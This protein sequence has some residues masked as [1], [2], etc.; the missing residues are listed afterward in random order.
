MHDRNRLGPRLIP[1]V[2]KLVPFAL[3]V[4]ESQARAGASAATALI[5]GAYS[6]LEGL[7]SSVPTFIG[8]Q[9]DKVF[10]AALSPELMSLSHVKGA[11]AAKARA[12]LLSAAA[13]KLPAKTLYPAIIRLHASLDGKQREPLLGLLDLL[14]RALRYGKTGDV[15]ANYRAIFKLFLTVFDLRRVHATE[16]DDEDVVV[17]E[18]NALGAFVQFI[19]K[20]NEHM[21]RPLFLR[22][23]DWA[24]IDLAE[25]GDA[26]SAGVADEGL[27]ARRTVLYK[28]VDRLLGQLR[29]IFVPYFSFMLDQTVELLDAA[30]KGDLRDSD[31]WQAVAGALAKAFEYD[32]SGAS[33]FFLSPCALSRASRIEADDVIAAAQVSGR[34]RAWPSS[35][36]P[37][38]TSS[39]PPRPSSPSRPSIRS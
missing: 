10:S 17:I 36:R 30:A 8:G 34:A 39:R 29:S 38:R 16:L 18:D 4:L 13:K 3:D 20:L 25:A 15:G 21:F 7:F 2:A 37:S 26:A 12:A 6:T 11:S 27:V 31:L 19:L 22:T 14:N 28:V 1:L 24:V 33:F 35:L 32:E 9:L 5:S 23:Y